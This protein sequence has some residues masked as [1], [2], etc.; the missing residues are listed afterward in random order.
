MIKCPVQEIAWTV[1]LEEGVGSCIKQL[2]KFFLHSMAGKSVLPNSQSGFLQRHSCVNMIFVT[3]Q[4]VEK[5]REHK[6]A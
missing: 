6:V 5:I 2:Q 3:R 4:L 1:L